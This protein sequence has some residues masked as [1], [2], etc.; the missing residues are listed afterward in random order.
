MQQA[1]NR[2]CFILK[3]ATKKHSNIHDWRNSR[4]VFQACTAVTALI[5]EQITQLTGEP[6]D[7]AFTCFPSK[8]GH[9]FAPRTIDVINRMDRA[10]L[11]SVV[12]DADGI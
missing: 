4:G 5:N 8:N 2:A 6:A 7:K 9:L 10:S 12:F 11:L 3:T 1:S